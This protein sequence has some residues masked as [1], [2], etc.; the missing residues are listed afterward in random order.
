MVIF[1]LHRLLSLDLTHLMRSDD[2]MILD[3]LHLV[4]QLVLEFRRV[5]YCQ[6]QQ[7]LQLSPRLT[8]NLYLLF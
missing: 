2:E 3:L 8:D 6:Q 5:S 1:F 4:Q 7:L